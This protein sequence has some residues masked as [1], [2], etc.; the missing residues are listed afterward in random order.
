MSFRRL[1]TA[2]AL[3]ACATASSISTALADPVVGVDMSCVAPAGNPAPNTPEWV[4]RDTLNQYCAGLRNRDQLANPAFGFGNYME[5]TNL[6]VDQTTEQL[7]DPTHPRGGTT[8][9]I[10][11]S[12]GADPFRSIRR[13][14]AAGLG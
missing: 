1:V 4:Q 9:L 6:Y 10:P 11:G 14:T 8:T 12:K 13:W 5:G 7:S 3:V 2:F